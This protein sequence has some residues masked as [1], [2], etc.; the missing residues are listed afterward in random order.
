M[1]VKAL[2]ALAVL[3]L[4]R[5]AGRALDGC[6][7]LYGPAGSPSLPVIRTRRSR[8]GFC[9]LRWAMVDAREQRL[10]KNEVMFRDL[11]ERVAHAAEAQGVD[12]H[13]FEFLC[14]CSNGDCTLRVRLTLSAYE[15]VR[16]DP[17]QFVVALGHELPEIEN[18]VARTNEYQVVEKLG[19]AANYARIEDPRG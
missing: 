5:F 10:V 11:N 3:A 15:A 13:V 17:A 8:V 2:V 19:G 7:R 16:S 6:G 4:R 12:D 14:E 18:V 1:R 9:G